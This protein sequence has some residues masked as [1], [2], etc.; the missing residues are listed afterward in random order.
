MSSPTTKSS[1]FASSNAQFCIL[2]SNSRFSNAP[3]MLMPFLLRNFLTCATSHDQSSGSSVCTRCDKRASTG[4]AVVQAPVHTAVLTSLTGNPSQHLAPQ[5]FAQCVKKQK[6]HTYRQLSYQVTGPGATQSVGVTLGAVS[7]PRWIV[8]TMCCF[9][10]HSAQNPFSQ[11]PQTRLQD[12]TAAITR[13]YWARA[14]C[15]PPT[16]KREG[17]ATV[18]ALIDCI[19]V[20]SAKRQC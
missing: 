12:Q 7:L 19:Q 15:A 17:R 20:L 4:W 8:S 14:A 2:S 3:S 13:M 5:N 10:K 16:P 1:A 9:F 6:E 11:P 18:E